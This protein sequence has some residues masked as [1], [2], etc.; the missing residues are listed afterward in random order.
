MESMRI[1]LSQGKYAIVDSADFDM[2]SQFK[3]CYVS[4]GRG[5]A[6]RGITRRHKKTGGK[7]EHITIQM[8]RFILNAKPGEFVDHISGDG[9]DNRRSNIRLVS[10]AENSRNRLLGKNNKSGFKG[11]HWDKYH[12]RFVVR[13]R[14]NGR[15]EYAGS[16]KLAEEAARIYDEAAIKH[17]GKFAKTNKTLCLI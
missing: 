7:D 13:I 15:S 16:S 2:V 3:W 12:G 5:Y 8:H 9:L 1:P 6:T 11:V 14:V 17:Y 4:N 10:N